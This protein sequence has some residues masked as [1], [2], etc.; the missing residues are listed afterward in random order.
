MICSFATRL[1]T[2]R[3]LVSYSTHIANQKRALHAIARPLSALLISFLLLSFLAAPQPASAQPADSRAARRTPVVDVFQSCKNSVVNISSTQIIKVQSNSGIDSL[4]EQMFDLPS[5]GNRPTKEV[6]QTSVGSGFVLHA[7]GYI[8]TNAHVVAR[9]AERK[10]IFP[11]KSEFDAQVVAI[12][13]IRDLAVLKIDADRPLQPLR[14]GR[15]ADLMIGETVIAIGNPLGYQHT[16]TAGVV[17]ALDRTIDLQNEVSIK[18][19]I[20]TDASINPGNSG[21]P[22]LN[23]LGELIGI[24]SAIRGDAQ[25]I[26]FAIPVDQLRDALPGLLDVQR[27]YRIV[28]GLTVARDGS[29]K[30][31]AVDQGSPADAAGIA[32]GDVVTQVDKMPVPTVIDFHILLIGRHPGDVLPIRFTRQDKPFETKIT[33]G[34]RPKPDAPKLLA[35]KFG[36]TAEPLAEKTSRSLGLPNLRGLIITSIVRGTPADSIGLERGDIIDQINSRQVP[37]LDAAGETLETIDSG[38]SVPM[39]VLRVANRTIYRSQVRI[40]IR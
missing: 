29:A 4:L 32:V 1:A 11:D 28:T 2:R 15:S 10:V 30:V 27:R 39:S 31:I 8:V 37:T 19:L 3:R 20:Q 21:G 34:Q 18:G 16:V 12:D 25:N 13:P 9:T 36:I 38:T 40:K 5:Q 35:D 22:L 14:L 24:N 23:V 17:S 7:A 33:L 26:G 6:R